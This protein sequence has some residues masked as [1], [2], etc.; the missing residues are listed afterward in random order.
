MNLW[1][2]LDLNEHEISRAGNEIYT[3]KDGRIRHCV[4][5]GSTR[6]RD[7]TDRSQSH[8]Y[9]GI[10]TAMARPAAVLV[11]ELSPA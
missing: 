3:A 2:G 10:R 11:V 8:Q 9:I 1:G 6:R 5:F 7:Q 4:S